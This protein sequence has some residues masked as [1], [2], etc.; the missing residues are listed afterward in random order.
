MVRVISTKRNL[1]KLLILECVKQLHVF[2]V[3]LCFLFVDLSRVKKL[4]I[5]IKM[6]SAPI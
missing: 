1:K 2:V 4:L 5:K 6:L 3:C